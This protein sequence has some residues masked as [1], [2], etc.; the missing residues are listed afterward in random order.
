MSIDPRDMDDGARASA[1]QLL[2][3]AAATPG[4]AQRQLNHTIDDFYVPDDARLDD[5]TRA[6]L[7]ATLSAIVALVED[8]VRRHAS[9]ALA[10]HGDAERAAQISTG[11]P[12]FNRLVE[13]GLLR[14]PE[15]MRDLLARTRQDLLSDA[16]PALPNEDAGASSLLALLSSSA[17]GAVASAALALMATESRRRGFLDT[18]RMTLT[19]LPAELHHRLVWWVA[20]TIRA[21]AGD[22]EADRAISD[23]ALRS[24]A[25]HDESDRVEAAAVR[26]ASAVNAQ[27]A[28]LTT[29]LTHALGDRRVALFIAFLGKQLGVDFAVAREMVVDGGVQLWVGLRAIGLEREAIARIGLSL[30]EADPRRSV[31]DFADQLDGIMAVEPDEARSALAALCLH[32]DFRAAMA[33]LEQQQ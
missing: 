16:L 14:D 2:A 26:L 4:R 30:C 6:T 7:T 3:F 29:L 10:A 12:V 21:Q 11:E 8:D 19:E 24:L 15:L 18:G 22:A 13:T 1:S 5:R 32:S 28:E 23:G 25:T 33:L 27:T 20:A 31:D 9:R 17:D